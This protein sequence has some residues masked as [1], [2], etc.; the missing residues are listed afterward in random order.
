M[1]A[2]AQPGERRGGRTSGTANK[3]KAA[4]RA[5][6]NA[7]FPDWDPVL[8][9]AKIATTTD[10]PMM[11]LQACK[12]VAQYIHPK[13]KS[14]EHKGETRDRITIV[15]WDGKTDTDPKDPVT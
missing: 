12:E 7:A 2:G 9:M 15:N 6:V 13:L 10:D 8:A 11:E 5:M 4:L 14:I 3:D 1:A